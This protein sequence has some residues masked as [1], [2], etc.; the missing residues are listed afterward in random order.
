L[1]EQVVDVLNVPEE[2]DRETDTFNQLK[3]VFI[4]DP[5]SSLDENHL[6]EL[7]V[8]LAEL[9]KSSDFNTNKVKFI[10]TTHNP[11]FY[12]V[13][14]SELSLKT[15]YLLRKN[16]DETLDLDEKKGDS[17]KSFSYHL[18]IK[19][20]IEDAI[21]QESIEKFH[22]MLLR[23]LYEKTANFLDYPEWSKLLPESA[24]KAYVKLINT[25]SHK[26]LSSEEVQEP[27]EPEKQTV[28]LLFNHLINN[29]KYWQEAEENA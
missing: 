14:Y 23:N 5:V 3:Y 17:N 13:L 12:N 24:R 20:L 6:I 11:L 8:S 19:K 16:E 7:A 4:D 26:T 21:K 27:T 10:I 9:I 15:G 2:T 25:H 1:I 22:F 18:Y 29:S 28:K